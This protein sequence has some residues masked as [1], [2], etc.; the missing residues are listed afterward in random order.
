VRTYELTGFAP[1]SGAW[2]SFDQW[3][4]DGFSFLG[5]ATEI[6]YEAEAEKG[7]KQKRL[8]ASE[9]TLYRKDDLTGFSPLGKVESLALPGE[10][11][12]LALTPSLVA[13]VFKRKLINAPDTPEEVLIPEPIE[14]LT[15]KGADQGGYVAWDGGWWIPSGRIFYHLAANI[16]NPAVTS[17]MEW[18]AARHHF[19][20]PRKA[21]DA[22]NYSTTVDYDG[23][24]LLLT[25]SVDQVGNTISVE[26]DYRVLQAREITD[27][28]RNRAASAFDAFGLVVAT[29]VMGKSEEHLGDVLDGFDLDLTLADIRGFVAN[30][31]ETALSLLGNATLRV[32]Y[33]IDRYRRS[34]QPPFAAILARETHYEPVRDGET[35]IQVTIAFSD[36]FGREIQTKVQAE[37]GE[38]F[39]RE[40]AV[41]LPCGDLLPGGLVR[42]EQDEITTGN[43]ARRWVG[44]G[45]TVFNNKGKPVKQYDPFFSA[46]HL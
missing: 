33:D 31:C 13:Q 11:Y 43:V 41:L 10:A 19:F 7:K 23:H 37:P 34:G 27:P 44:T 9:R 6:P 8:I 4:Q 14:P 28:N 21:A 12:R 2:F 36:G 3:T 22:F 17:G 26:N 30:P 15:G 38:A 25:R 29:A 5:S 35:K 1:E 18:E 32:V 20:L 46:T 40:S 39:L 16:S 24:D 45:R 42:G